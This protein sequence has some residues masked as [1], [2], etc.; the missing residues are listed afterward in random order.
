MAGKGLVGICTDLA[1]CG[2]DLRSCM[3]DAVL[4]KDEQARL[5]AALVCVNKYQ[6]CKELAVKDV[7]LERETKK[8]QKRLKTFG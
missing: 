4:I 5:K 1:G 7:A 8:I 2:D 6:D 3:V